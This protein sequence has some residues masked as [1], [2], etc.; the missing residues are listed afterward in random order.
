M[1]REGAVVHGSIGLK[2]DPFQPAAVL[3]CVQV[4]AANGV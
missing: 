3:Q 1:S 4:Q 2:L